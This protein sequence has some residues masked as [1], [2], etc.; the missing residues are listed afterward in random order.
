M[1]SNQTVTP[2]SYR[3]NRLEVIIIIP[4]TVGPKPFTPL[5]NKEITGF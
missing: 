3:R 1:S 4:F 5:R 2:L